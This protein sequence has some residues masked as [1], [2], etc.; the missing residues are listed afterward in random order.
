MPIDIS[1]LDWCLA[2]PPEPGYT[3]VNDK[4]NIILEASIRTGEQ[5]GAQVFLTN[6]GLVAKIYDPLYYPLFDSF[7]TSEKLDVTADA[8]NDYAIEV[9]AYSE[10][11]GTPFQGS[12]MPEYHGSWSTEVATNV[13]GQQHL[14]EVR[15][16]LLEHI[17]GTRMMD[18]NPDELK[19]EE[20]ENIMSKMIEADTDLRLAGLQHDDL[21]PRNVMLS[22]PSQLESS[23]SDVLDNASFDDPGLRVCIVDYGR[24]CVARLVGKK[25]PEP[26]RFNPLFRWAGTDIYSQYGWL[27]PFKEAMDWMWEKWGDGGSDGKYVKV[28]RD[29][30]DPLGPPMDPGSDRPKMDGAV[31]IWFCV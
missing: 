4:R 10:F 26:G 22:I 1:Q 17:V 5:N 8:N 7:W 29:L 31:D 3:D 23:K 30:D 24:S 9:A 19:R 12:I 25:L 20:K 28:Q 6:D 21:E 11:Q 18:I 14:R 15:M 2:H 16:I 13:N 27:P